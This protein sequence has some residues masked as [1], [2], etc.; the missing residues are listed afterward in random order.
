[1]FFSPRNKE[2][3]KNHILKECNNRG[4]TQ[5]GRPQIIRLDKTL[6]H[7]MNEVWTQ[8]NSYPI[9]YLNREVGSIAQKDFI[10]YLSKPVAAAQT[11]RSVPP[12]PAMST[13]IEE[14]TGGSIPTQPRAQPQNMIYQDTGRTLEQLQKER[15][16]AQ[17]ERPIIPDF[18]INSESDD[19][20]SPLEL[21]E[22]AK[23][24]REREAANRPAA[25]EN[26]NPTYTI[27]DTAP[28]MSS[29]AVYRT[30]LGSD[31]A[32]PTGVKPLPPPI[33]TKKSH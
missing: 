6:G 32:I 24:A 3:L 28:P 8:A 30:I 15:Q 13:P 4:L 2:I 5:L 20:P 18:R 25:I 14:I 1:M 29:A 27:D 22:M 19:G 10:G 9:P 7:Y 11:I 17:P 16:G 31:I 23:V 12:A 21:Y 26:N 33:K